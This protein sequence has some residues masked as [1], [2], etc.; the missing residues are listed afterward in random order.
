MHPEERSVKR[1]ANKGQ[2]KGGLFGVFFM[3]VI[4]DAH[5]LD[6]AD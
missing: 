4:M 5:E 2:K 6:G 1:R 3:A